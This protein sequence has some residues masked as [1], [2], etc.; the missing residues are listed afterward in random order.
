MGE[1]AMFCPACRAD[2]AI[3]GHEIIGLYDGV[4]F[5]SCLECG[6]RWHRFHPGTRVHRAVQALWDQEGPTD[7]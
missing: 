7:A 4:A 6:E 1:R 3:V 2:D 5:W